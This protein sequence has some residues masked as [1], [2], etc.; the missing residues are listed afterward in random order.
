MLS[1]DYSQIEL[2]VLAH[3]SRDEALVDPGRSLVL[4]GWPVEVEGSEAENLWAFHVVADGPGRSRLLSRIK[5][6]H[7]PSLTER[8]F[9]SPLL[10]EPVGFVMGR[11]ML[12]GIKARA[13]QR[14]MPAG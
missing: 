3:L 2:R 10:V 7:G 9:F 14:P 5:A 1:A 12:L 8:L 13:E 4:R 11:E 6:T